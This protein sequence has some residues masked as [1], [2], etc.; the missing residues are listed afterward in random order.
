ML[1]KIHIKLCKFKITTQLIELVIIL[2]R[3]VYLENQC[4]TYF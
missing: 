1:K 3:E 2:Y 4:W